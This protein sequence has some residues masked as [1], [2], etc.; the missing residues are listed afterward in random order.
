MKKYSILSTL[1]AATLLVGCEQELADLKPPVTT[2][3][4]GSIGTNINVS[5]FVTIGNSLVAGYQA[6]ALFN[7]GQDES[8]G[9]IINT[10]FAF[11]GGTSEF[12]QPTINSVNGFSGLA[13]SIPLGRLILFD[14]DGPGP[15]GAG[16]AAS[17]TPARSVTCPS[18]VETPAVP[19]PY[20]SGDPI[21]PFT[22]DKG[23]L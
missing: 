19:A 5:N 10:Q 1:F 2:T 7:E 3:P 6:S 16:P 13:G 4:T 11:A 17:G 9:K 12:N 15:R 14:P 21:T 8:L 18:V 20:N 23:K 22:G